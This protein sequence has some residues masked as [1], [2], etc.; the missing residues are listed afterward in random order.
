MRR[1]SWATLLLTVTLLPAGCPAPRVP[2]GPGTGT[3][4]TTSTPADPHIGTSGGATTAGPVALRGRLNPAQA[5]K[6]RARLQATDDAEHP[7]TIVAQSD[8]TGKLYRTQTDTDGD[9][10]LPI[11]PDEVGNTFVVTILGPDGRAVG[12]VVLKTTGQQGVTGLDLQRDADLGTINLPAN[13]D[14]Q[15]ITP[16]P[17]GDAAALA[18]PSVTARLREDGV[19][20][21]SGC[22]GKGTT[23]QAAERRATGH[24]DIDR[25]GLIDLF[26]A[27]DDGDGL[28]DDLDKGD[29]WS[30]VPADIRVN[31]FMNLKVHAQL[32]P[33]FYFGTAAQ[34]AEALATH[35]VITFEVLSE[36]GARRAIAAANLLE[37]PGP[38]YLP[39]AQLL[40]RFERWRDSG[41]ALQRSAGRFEAFV[42]P[43]AV[44]NA[45]D[46]FTL[47]VTFD[48]GATVEVA[49]MIN[50]VFK[51]IPALVRYGAPDALS[52]FDVTHPTANGCPWAPLRFDATRDL[53]LV[54]RPPPDET[55]APLTGTDYAFDIFFNRTDGA[56]LN[57]DIDAA[58]TWPA[59]IAGWGENNSLSYRV[60]AANMGTLSADGTY[61]VR[62]PRQIFVSQVALRGGGTADVASYQIDIAAVV[63]TGNAALLLTFA[64][65]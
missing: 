57:A 6:P 13:P 39:Q 38:A 29:E 56:Q 30:G 15:P 40:G 11:P 33:V 42:V 46:T 23:A 64:R 55:G 58:A 49:R 21:G 27:D 48:D 51:S 10:E 61:T 34:I 32:A 62:L 41:Y 37:T 1:A 17:D 54:F 26:D 60:R 18:D 5:T 47:R 63:P 53:V 4:N 8:Q 22:L 16:G 31:F 59:A 50:Y 20:L 28:L 2:T 36:P 44:M 9:F 7:Y 52:T 19:P 14:A 65:Q 25:D 12:P 3:T 43:L 35:T 45:G 24:A